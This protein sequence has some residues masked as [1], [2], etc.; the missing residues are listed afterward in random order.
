MKNL[1]LTILIMVFVVILGTNVF[2]QTCTNGIRATSCYPWQSND[3]I[4]ANGKQDDKNRIQRALGN[5]GKVL[6]DEAEY[7]VSGDIIIPS[8]VILEGTGRSSEVVPVPTPTPPTSTPPIHLS[9]K[10]IL[11]LP[12]GVTFPPT[13]QQPA[14]LN[15]S[16]FK[17]GANIAEVSIRDLA[18]IVDPALVSNQFFTNQ[19]VGIL[20]TAN[21]LTNCTSY[22]F[23][24]SNLSFHKF[25]KGIYVNA[26]DGGSTAHNWQFDNVRLDHTFFNGCNTGV[27]INS[28]NS[29]WDISSIE[30][31][32]PINGIGFYF[33]RSTYTSVNLVIGN[34]TNVAPYSDTLFKVKEHANLSIKNSV[35]EWFREDININNP[36]AS[37]AASP[38]N[39]L[40]NW[41]NGKVTIS[42]GMVVSMG[43]T[44][45]NQFI[46]P[47]QAIANNNSYIYS[48]G[49][50][51][52]DYNV[53]CSN[54]WQLN[55]GSKLVFG[56]DI[57][58]TTTT[59][60]TSIIRNSPDN[61]D[62]SPN[63]SLIAPTNAAGPLFRLGTANY[64]YDITRSQYPEDPGYLR[65][66]ATQQGYGGYTF[67]TTT[68]DEGDG[69]TT[70]I[71][72]D[73]SVTL[74]SITYSELGVAQNSSTNGTMV[75]CDDC[76]ET[77]PCSDKGDGAI[78]KKVAGR[79]DCN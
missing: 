58:K 68:T 77:D 23:Q 10:I 9:S 32:A 26:T 50:K 31:L 27:H 30:F 20:A 75:Y 69:G 8:Y 59:S 72:H 62:I 45:A 7:Y 52:C 70:R 56:S 11:T 61:L 78:A 38:I 22:G 13:S 40:N 55:S 66:V 42:N 48:I 41:F 4:L 36:T 34:G 46:A 51:F 53:P 14:T 73:G 18:L 19:T 17:I 5:P 24:F 64:F 44:F 43:N 60:P 79:W 35:T 33:E 12:T 57:N 49:D 47:T 76:S 15:K 71:N 37:G 6:F 63:L 65:F 54:N 39:L 21:C 67:K 1:I 3:G 74:G 28:Y 29:G 16:I 2:G 25:D